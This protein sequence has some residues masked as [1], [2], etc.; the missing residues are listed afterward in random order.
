MEPASAPTTD[1]VP[2]PPGVTAEALTAGQRR[3]LDE[4][5]YLVLPGA[6]AADVVGRLRSAFDRACEAQGVPPRGTRHPGGLV[7]A[8]PAFAGFLTHPPLL[9]AV[10]H[11][12]GAPFRLGAV[13]GRDPLPGYGQQGLHIDCVDPGPPAPYRV[14]AALGLVDDF[15]EENGATRVVPGS[16]RARRPPPKGFADPAGRHPDE[17]LVTAPAGSVL[18]FNGHLWHGGTRNRSGGHRRAV[19]CS[20][21]AAG[22]PGPPHSGH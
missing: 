1:G 5:G 21:A 16:H 19:R 8:D 20:F 15:T 4:R 17:I 10:R 7:D 3:A 22:V 9:A 12:L 14:V 11:V 2:A 13:A 6:V 18:V